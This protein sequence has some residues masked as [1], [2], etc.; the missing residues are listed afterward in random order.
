[1]CFFPVAPVPAAARIPLDQPTPLGY[2]RAMLTLNTRSRYGLAALLSLATGYEQGL[3]QA[4]EIANHHGIPPKYLEQIL[5]R[6]TS[7]ELVQSVRGKHGGYRLARPPAKISVL[8]AL[9]A[10][11]GGLA[12]AGDNGA[13]VPEAVTALFEEA[14]AALRQ[15]FSISLA[16]LA[17]RQHRLARS[18]IFHI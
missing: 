9:E 4:K 3:V 11:E 1:M 7:T 13:T 8:E 16:E 14:E 5:V 12:L 15:V 18:L 2:N 6:L 17:E 10:L